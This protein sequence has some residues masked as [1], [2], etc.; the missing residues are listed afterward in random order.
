[1][2]DS[3]VITAKKKYK[4]SYCA[5]MNCSNTSSKRPDLSFFRFPIDR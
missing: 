5:A 3:T 2:D 4:G 1:M